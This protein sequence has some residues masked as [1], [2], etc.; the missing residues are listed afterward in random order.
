MSRLQ[1]NKGNEGFSGS[2]LRR[3][4]A[5]GLRGGTTKVARF[6]APEKPCVVVGFGVE[7]F[8]LY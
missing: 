4:S 2:R 8:E 7:V 1:A 5:R 3:R 6:G